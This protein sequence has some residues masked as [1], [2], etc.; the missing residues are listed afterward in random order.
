MSE[1]YFDSARKTAV[2]NAKLQM[3][4]PDSGGCRIERKGKGCTTNLPGDRIYRVTECDTGV[5]TPKTRE[6]THF[7]LREILGE[8]KTWEFILQ[9]MLMI[10]RQNTVICIGLND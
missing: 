6:M 1:K 2:L 7:A 3:A 8:Q 10:K 4:L 9:Q 5:G